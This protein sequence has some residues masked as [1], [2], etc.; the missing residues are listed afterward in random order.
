MLEAK[1][2]SANGEE[3]GKIELPEALFGLNTERT[4]EKNPNALLYEVVKMYLANQRQG[5]SLAKNRSAVKG[6]GKKLYKQ[7]GTGNARVGNRRTGIRVGGGVAFGPVPKDWYRKIPKKKK[8]LALKLALSQQAKENKVFIVESIKYDKP[9]TKK[10]LD[11]I[12]KIV[13]EKGKKLVVVDSSDV[14]IVKSFSNI[15]KVNMDRADG[16]YAYEILNNPYLIIT[17]DA[18]NKM[19]TVFTDNTEEV[20]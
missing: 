16:L 3:I 11:L 2:Y 18:L 12:N 20:K 17:E 8:R 9:S 15:E 1:K 4:E 10:A 5:T 19:V 13:P 6:S 14:N 7:K